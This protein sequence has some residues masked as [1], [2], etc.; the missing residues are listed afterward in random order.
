MTDSRIKIN[1]CRI[2][3]ASGAI[4]AAGLALRIA[5]IY[6][7]KIAGNPALGIVAKV[8]TLA[9]GAGLVAGLTV[10]VLKRRE[11]DPHI[12][13]KLLV[14]SL[15]ALVAGAVLMSVN[16]GHPATKIGGP[17]LLT[18]GGAIL[19]TLLFYHCKY[20]KSKSSAD[21]P[22]PVNSEPELPHPANAGLPIQHNPEEGGLSPFEAM[23]LNNTPALDAILSHLRSP[24][25]LA[26]L[27]Q[28]SKA[29]YRLLSSMNALW[30]LPPL[31][32][33][34]Q[35]EGPCTA[36]RAFVAMQKGLLKYTN[37]NPPT[38]LR[39]HTNSIRCLT[40]FNDFL[41]TGSND[42]TI[43]IWNLTTGDQLRCLM[44]HENVIFT[45]ITIG[46]LLASGSLDT[47]VR[48]WNPDTGES[49]HCLTDH[50]QGV[51]HLVTI[52]NLLASA[53]W[54]SEDRH[55]RIWN[56]HTGD[57]L[58]RLEG[59]T[60]AIPSLIAVDK[61]L[62][63]GD[64]GGI[65]GSTIRIWNP[66]TGA[67]LHCLEVQAS[68]VTHMTAIGGLVAYACVVDT[69]IR[70]L[71]PM[72]GD[73]LHKLECNNSIWS[74][75][76]VGKVLISTSGNGHDLLVNNIAS[77]IWNPTT[78]RTLHFMPNKGRHLYA[79][80]NFFASS[81]GQFY[82]TFLHIWDIAG[83]EVFRLRGSHNH[84]RAIGPFLVAVPSY[85][86][87]NPNNPRVWRLT[88]NGSQQEVIDQHVPPLFQ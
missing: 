39:G 25:D 62:V 74:I 3:I 65:E 57:L 28:T 30:K 49:L 21:I 34:E 54:N 61:L 81:L 7:S 5:A 19:V 50:T 64:L 45:L 16:M 23:L 43:R 72:T 22:Q 77:T 26:A 31:F 18:L 37:T 29:L 35:L 46:N 69:Q 86:H 10:N 85:A 68:G 12:Y 83:R 44:G 24:E 20:G 1:S 55:I 82:E 66:A 76:T 2:A 48:I 33:V 87:D 6:V 11:N 13:R 88:P 14:A 52:D 32:P 70:I 38:I 63:S 60:G 42:T 15:I 59:H 47:T 73:E 84:L 8:G 17:P 78:G 53:A 40:T 58:Y 80:G 56:P 79:I 41:I 36:Y 9:G 27:M 71:N 75:I 51:S 4:L 67:Q